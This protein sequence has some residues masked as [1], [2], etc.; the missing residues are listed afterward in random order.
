VADSESEGG[1]RGR[2][3]GG[4]GPNN[5]VIHCVVQNSNIRTLIILK[6]FSIFYSIRY[7]VL[8]NYSFNARFCITYVVHK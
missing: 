6:T 7:I 2:G 4:G 3:V 8:I 1:R 5:N